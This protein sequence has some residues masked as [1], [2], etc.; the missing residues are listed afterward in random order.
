MARCR[1]LRPA[2]T[3]STVR[4][5][6]DFCGKLRNIMLVL[7][8]FVALTPL[9]AF[10]AQENPSPKPP[11]RACSDWDDAASGSKKKQAS[12]KKKVLPKHEGVCIELAFSPLDIQEYLQ[13]YGREAHWIISSDQLNEDSWTFSLE[14]NR[15]ELLR[16]TLPESGPKGVDWKHG[17]VRVHID[18][19]LL[20]DGYA[21]TLIHA[22]FRGFGRNSDQFAVQKEY[23]DL[24]SSKVFENSLAETLRNHFS[25]VATQTTPS[26]PSAP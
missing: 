12:G 18:S 14:L 8:L 7:L 16:D 26:A 20:P 6:C 25:R 19:V 22:S 3:G 5:L 9:P 23:W 10:P 2:S 15:E 11:V 21:R 13:S 1:L 4:Q 24:E 17:S